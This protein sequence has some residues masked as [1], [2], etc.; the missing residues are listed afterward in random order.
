[1]SRLS[2]A[3]LIAAL[4][5]AP[6]F[7]Q[8]AMT[9]QPKI[10]RKSP[11]LDALIA[12]DATFEKLSDGHKWTEGPVWSSRGGFL[13]WSD[14][15]NNVVQQVAAG[16]S[17][18]EFLKPSGYSGT[19][20]FTGPE[21]GSNGLTFDRQGRL[22]LCQHGDRRIARLDAARRSSR[23][24][25][26]KYEGK[27]LNSPNDARLSLVRRAVLHRSA[28]RPAEAL[29]RPEEGT[30]VPGRLPPAAPTAR[31]RCSRRS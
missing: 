13:L 25:A 15:P 12:S 21:P 9:P 16:G 19:E 11:A 1:M 23:A 4:A 31:S 2:V 17:V 8:T 29:G 3:L 27:R 14:I 5:V 28:V 20:P 30:D 7:S 10:D 26:D 18:T 6:L 22:M 24:L